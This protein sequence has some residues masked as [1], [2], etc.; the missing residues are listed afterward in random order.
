VDEVRIR[1]VGSIEKERILWVIKPIAQNPSEEGRRIR[2]RGR[3][4]GN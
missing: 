3:I 1:V 4:Y 2:S